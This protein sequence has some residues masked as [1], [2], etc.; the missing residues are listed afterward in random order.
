[1]RSIW[2]ETATH[3]PFE[4]LGGSVRTDVL[5][6]GGGMAG[7]LCSHALRNAGVEHLLVE[8]TRIGGI[9]QDCMSLDDVPYIGRY[10]KSTPNV[11]FA[12]GFNK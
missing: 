4:T 8:A 2:N 5:I 3:T 7:V 6:V 9:T 10:S 11:Y 1:M 12:T